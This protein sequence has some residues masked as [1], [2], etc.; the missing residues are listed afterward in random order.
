MKSAE[1]PA[2]KR[3]LLLKAAALT[4]VIGLLAIVAWPKRP[5]PERAAPAGAA[6]A[7]GRD[8][9]PV[10]SLVIKAQ[11]IDEF[12]VATGTVHAEESVDV[13]SETAGKLVKIHF[14][15]GAQVRAGDLLAVM[16]DAELRA[17]LARASYRRQLAELKA[18]RITTLVDK[19]GVPQQEYDIAA[20]ELQVLGAEVAVI[21][22]QL[23]RTEIR[24]PFS[25][26]IGLR[27]V[28]EGALVT[29]STR[30]ASLQ[31]TTSVKVDFNVPERYAGVV[32]PGSAVKFSVAGSDRTY[33]A[34]V[35]AVEPHL[36]EITRTR[37]I[38][39]RAANPDQSLIPG[40]FARV[41]VP[42]ARLEHALM[43][44]ATALSADAGEKSVFVI[45]KGKAKRQV[46]QTG[47]RRGESVLVTSG[48][49]NG[50]EVIVT[51]TQLVRNGSSVDASPAR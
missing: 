47:L 6:P 27:N 33:T 41:T 36:D 28:S 18:R 7:K 44:P 40:A 11:P 14:Q 32:T 13:Q 43:V 49:R 46:V 17:A 51:G 37:L 23:A 34:E 10:R 30:L 16:N 48:L 26:T 12:I 1:S 3:T 22:A 8:G 15:E 38:R 9:T 21:E 19:G 29:T 39:A 24:A 25:G 45:D 35:Y 20:S 50:D 5:A 4:G 2:L 31:N 42:L